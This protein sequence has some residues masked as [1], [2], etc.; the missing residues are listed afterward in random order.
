MLKQRLLHNSA[1]MREWGGD[2]NVADRLAIAAAT[3]DLPHPDNNPFLQHFIL[4]SVREA[5]D[6][7]REG[8]DPSIA[9]DDEF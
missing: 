8:Y 9:F 7:L 2:T 6:M 1:W 4:R 5:H 3:L